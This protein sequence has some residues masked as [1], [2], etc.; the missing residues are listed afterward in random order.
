MVTG[1]V[2]FAGETP[3]ETISLILQKGPAPLSRYTHEAPSEL[4]RIVTK[5]LT[6]DREQRYQ[7]AKDLL[8]DLR[9]LKR[10]LEVDAEIDRTV[11]PERFGVPPSGGIVSCKWTAPPEGGTP[12]TRAASSAEYIVTEVKHH[13]LAAAI[14]VIAVVLGA[15]GLFAYLHAR[16][17]EVAIDS[18]AVLPFDNQNRDPNTEYLAD[19]VTESIINSLTQLPNLKVIARS[20]V[21]RYKG[22]E[23]E[24]IAIGKELGVR[25]VLTGRIMQRGDNLTI[26]TELMEVR[27]NKQLW[28]EQYSVKVTDLLSV[29]REIATK[30][31]SNLRLKLSGAEQQQLA[32]RYTDN[33]DAYQFYLKG[34]YHLLKLT[35]PEIQTGISYFN[36][37]IEID[38]S[39]ALAYVGLADA[40]RVP[41]L[42]GEM[43]GTE[44]LPKAKAAA[45]KAIEIDDTLAEAHASLGFI[46]FC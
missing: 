42:I 13:K 24:P 45:Q 29:Q 12:N 44:V 37:A 35:P 15:V 25:A 10:K 31:T 16:N 20:S 21:F 27:D 33:V 11:P 38:P 39:Y 36:Q 4:E 8:I 30:I 40:Y 7:T 22:K 5:A 2:P 46:I 3:T 14:A 32:K 23:T 19:G 17:T 43:P 28:G 1:H 9:N 41:T 6:K 26:S 18:L 34:R